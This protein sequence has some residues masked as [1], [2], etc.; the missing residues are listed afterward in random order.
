MTPI[1][2]FN[3][4][5]YWDC[6][7]CYRGD[8]NDFCITYTRWYLLSIPG[9]NRLIIGHYKNNVYMFYSFMSIK[10]I[11]EVYHF[12]KVKLANIGTDSFDINLLERQYPLVKQK[13][14]IDWFYKII[15]ASKFDYTIFEKKNKDMVKIVDRCINLINKNYK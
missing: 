2:H 9:K 1:Q 10:Q 14:K 3:N 11:K 13:Y 12:D 5:G 6:S 4:A 15:K 7:K 8:H